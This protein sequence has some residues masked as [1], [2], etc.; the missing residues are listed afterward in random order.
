M[1]LVQVSDALQTLCHTGYADCDVGVLIGDKVYELEDLHKTT[2]FSK[3]SEKILFH[4]EIK[5]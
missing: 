5:K 3:D 4:L 1:R 2:S